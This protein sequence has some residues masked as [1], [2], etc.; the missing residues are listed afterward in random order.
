MFFLQAWPL[1]LPH[2][3]DVGAS[4]GSESTGRTHYWTKYSFSV[5]K[6]KILQLQ[7]VGPSLSCVTGTRGRWLSSLLNIL[8]QTGGPI[9]T[10]YTLFIPLLVPPAISTSS[11]SHQ[12]DNFPSPQA[13]LSPYAQPLVTYKMYSVIPE[14]RPDSKTQEKKCWQALWITFFLTVSR[15]ACTSSSKCLCPLQKNVNCLCQRKFFHCNELQECKAPVFLFVK[16][17]H[18]IPGKEFYSS[19]YINTIPRLFHI[20]PFLGEKMDAFFSIIHVG[21]KIC[22]HVKNNYSF[23][24]AV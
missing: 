10:F 5:C 9:K 2:F 3:L 15:F 6:V 4:L 13:F 7:N 18:L 16:F 11:V 8:L 20:N 21:L 22:Q 19:F 24:Q 1:I 14:L 17:G 12:R 23:Q